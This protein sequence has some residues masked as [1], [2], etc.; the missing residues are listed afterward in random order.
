MRLEDLANQIGNWMVTGNFEQYRCIYEN[1]DILVTH[2]I[3][4]FENGRREAVLQ[5]IL[6]KVGLLRR[7]ETGA[8]FLPRNE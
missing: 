5:S 3:A 6:K 2:N 8:T 4:T 1:D 7:G